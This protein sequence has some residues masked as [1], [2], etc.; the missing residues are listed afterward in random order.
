MNIKVGILGDARGWH[1]ILGQE[2]IPSEAVSSELTSEN[3]SAIVAGDD[4][5]DR[6][7]EMLRQYLHLG[8]AVLCS[9]T[10]YARIRQSTYQQASIRYILPGEDSKFS[11]VGLIDVRTRCRLAWN[12]NELKT[13]SGVYSAHI[14]RHEAG[15]VI[16]LPLDPSA[17]AFDLRSSVKSFYSPEDRLPFERVSFYNKSHVR[18]LVARSL[19]LLHHARGLPFVHWW[20]FPKDA[21]SVAVLRV[22]TDYGTQEEIRQLHGLA[23]ELKV[24][25]T[26]FVDVENQEP[27]LEMFKWMDSQEVGLHCFEHS[28]HEGYESVER[29]MKLGL[30]RLREVN[31]SASGYAAPVREEPMAQ[32]PQNRRQ[33]YADVRA[34]KHVVVYEWFTLFVGISREPPTPDAKQR[35]SPRAFIRRRMR[36]L[37]KKA[38]D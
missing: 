15:Y 6:E 37:D 28:V 36:E 3:Y 10:V 34:P 8:G 38:G 2:G 21:P 13:D 32:R 19:E 18:G 22:D 17:V 12:A 26:W 25:M 7:C 31:I 4:A 35:E 5:D 9:S 16:A 11:E 14:G 33:I 23:K 27:S 1:L 30:K 24:P 29:D 20:Y